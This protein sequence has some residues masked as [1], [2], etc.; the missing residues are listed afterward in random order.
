MSDRCTIVGNANLDV[1]LWP[2]SELIHSMLPFVD[3]FLPNAHEAQGLTGLADPQ[4]AAVELQATSG[5]WV[6]VK[7]GS[8]GCVAAGPAGARFAVD[9]MPVAAQDTTGAGDAFDAAL[10]HDLDAGREM[11]AAAEFAV[12]YATAVVQS[13][14]DGRYPSLPQPRGAAES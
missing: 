6:I 5:G 10:I 1:L 7:T 2:V 4:A 8:D 11:E 14:S 12:S 13:P 3:V 9:A